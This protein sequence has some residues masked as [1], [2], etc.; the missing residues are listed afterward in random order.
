[1]WHCVIGWV[2]PDLKECGAFEVSDITRHG[3]LSYETQILSN[4]PLKTSNLSLLMSIGCVSAMY[5]I[6][7]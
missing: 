2:V 4:F 6:K 1:M 3:S 7:F 5:L